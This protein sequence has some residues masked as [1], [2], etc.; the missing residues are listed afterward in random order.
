LLSLPAPRAASA[1]PFERTVAAMAEAREPRERWSPQDIDRLIE[2]VSEV[3]TSRLPD[4][5]RAFWAV[6]SKDQRMR[7][8]E[9]LRA[10]LDGERDDTAA[11][12]LNEWIRALSR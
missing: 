7:L 8:I 1:R 11:R 3:P 4:Y 6:T 9:D 10:R 12:T 5:L 2:R